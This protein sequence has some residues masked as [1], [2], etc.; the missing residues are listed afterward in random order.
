[1]NNINGDIKSLLKKLGDR[2]KR[3]RLA[4]NESQ[5]VFAARIGLTRQS[6]SK[7]EKGVASISIG[8]WLAASDILDRLQTWHEVLGE[9]EDLFEQFEQKRLKRKRA[10]GKRGRGK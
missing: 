2:L 7:M 1:M 3:A 5:D 8:Y 6:Y 4:R 10:S 9:K